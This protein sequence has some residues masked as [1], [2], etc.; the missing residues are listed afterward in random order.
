MDFNPCGSFCSEFAVFFMH[1]S[2]ELFLLSVIS[3]MTWNLRYKKDQV[4]N[5]KFIKEKREKYFSLVEKI[6][7]QNGN[8]LLSQQCT[9]TG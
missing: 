3:Q 6:G 5:Q 7:S 4:V 2:D 9:R 8:F 1:F